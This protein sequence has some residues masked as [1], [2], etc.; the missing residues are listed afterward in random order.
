M[1]NS[2]YFYV[3]SK[4]ELILWLFFSYQS[5]TNKTLKTNILL[6]DKIS[7][8]NFLKIRHRFRSQNYVYSRTG[9]KCAPYPIVSL[10]PRKSACDRINRH[11]SHLWWVL[12]PLILSC[13]ILSMSIQI[14]VIHNDHKIIF[15]SISIFVVLKINFFESM[16]LRLCKSKN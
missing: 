9:K 5:K 4:T 16:N 15:I 10:R 13:W 2:I 14:T 12:F 6:I 3:S 1:T 11:W 8:K 7:N